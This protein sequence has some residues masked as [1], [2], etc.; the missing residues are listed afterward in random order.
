MKKPAIGGSKRFLTLMTLDI[1]SG[2]A[3][4]GTT[5]SVPVGW[6]PARCLLKHCAVRSIVV[7]LRG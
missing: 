5:V 3:N 2:T 6:V 7:W 1:G 4:M